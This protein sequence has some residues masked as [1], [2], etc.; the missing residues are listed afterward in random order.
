MSE[1]IEVGTIEDIPVLGSR[2][3][4]MA[5][6]NVALFR[7]SDNKV[8][9][10]RNECPH[11]KGPLSEGIVHGH[12]VTCPLHNWVIALDTGLAAAPD[13]GCAARYPVELKGNKVFLGLN[14]E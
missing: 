13:E 8:F 11:K 1:F 2:V 6:G 7:T 12:S 3:V 9:A 5:K 14:A 10:L 4:E